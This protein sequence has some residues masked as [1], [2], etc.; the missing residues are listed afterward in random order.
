MSR[1]SFE[2][3]FRSLDPT[4]QLT[5]E[6]LDSMF[7][8]ER[9][10]GQLSE[11]KRRSR[12]ESMRKRLWRRSVVVST[13]SVLVVAGVATAITLA[14]APVRKVAH[15]TCY[16]SVS[17]KST[18]DV[19]PYGSNPLA[20]CAQVMHWQAP[21]G[22]AHGDGLLC[23]LSDGSLAAFPP[24]SG[25]ERCA[26]LGLVAFN[27]RLASPRV[28]AFQRAAE[29]YFSNLQCDKSQTAKVSM[30]HLLGKFG[31]VGWRVE[32]TGSKSPAACATL[33]FEVDSKLVDIVGIVRQVPQG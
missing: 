19:T 16:Q 6:Q 28:A 25:S 10:L 26:K 1:E 15:M 12:F 8:V 3:V 31:V 7:S 14:Q 13:I 21:N 30:L 4:K 9:L 33:A 29:D 27:G 20:L 22:G 11:S 17:L 18:A 5:N 24:S 23:I 32:V 2:V